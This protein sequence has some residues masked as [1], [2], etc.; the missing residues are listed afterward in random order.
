MTLPRAT[1]AAILVLAASATA[2]A[3][4][5]GDNRVDSVRRIP[6]PGIKV[7]SED[8]KALEGGLDA[9]KTSIEALE[10]RKD[11]RIAARVPDVRVFY[12]AVHD[13]LAY[14][15]FFNTR[16]VVRAK[17]LLAE[18]SRRAS[19]LEDGSAD[20]TTQ[21]GLVVRGYVSKIDGSVQPY[22]LVIPESY[23]PSTP[24]RLDVWFHGRG[25]T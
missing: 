22:G 8:R 13:A 21:K 14:D 23:S 11:A 24:I 16:D 1:I 6:G 9:L 2:R 15:E 25:E 5:P 10:K 20:W 19:Q 4:G 17:E 18:G 3:D 7:G 12:K